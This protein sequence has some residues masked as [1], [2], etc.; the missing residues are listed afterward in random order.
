MARTEEAKVHVLTERE[1]IARANGLV[2]GI[3]SECSRVLIAIEERCKAALDVMP[4][5]G[6]A[7]REEL[8]GFIRDAEAVR[9]EVTKLWKRSDKLIAEGV[10]V[11]PLEM[12]LV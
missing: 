7:Q 1:G 11:R 4:G 8:R 5:M 12:E 2:A 10:Y 3:P 9:E 6:E